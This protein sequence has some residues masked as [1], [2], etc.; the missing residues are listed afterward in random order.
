MLLF[1]TLFGLFVSLILF[2]FNAIQYPSSIYLSLFFSLSAFTVFISIF[3]YI[4][5]Q[6]S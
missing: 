6:K 4:L 3:C 5:I 2:L 1:L